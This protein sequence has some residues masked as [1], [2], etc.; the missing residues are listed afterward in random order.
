VPAAAVRP[1]APRDC[2]VQVAYARDVI[3]DLDREQ[4]L[5]EAIVRPLAARVP[6]PGQRVVD[7]PG[8]FQ[9]L[10]P[11][12][13]DGGFNEVSHVQLADD[14]ADAVIDATLAEYAAEGVRFKWVVSPSCRP[15][16]LAQRLARRG[17]LAHRC[18]VMAADIADVCLDPSPDVAVERVEDRAV[19]AYADVVA[20]GWGTPARPLADYQRLVLADPGD[21]HHSYLARVDGVPAGAANHVLFDRSAYL[22]GGVVLPAWRG[23]GAYRSLIAARLAQISG[24]GVR[25]VTTLAMAETSAPILTRLGFTPIAELDV[26]L[27]R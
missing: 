3:A 18:V 22:M 14:E 4:I 27:N 24:A 25:L 16:D 15:R 13:R 1:T 9:L 7:R 5:H 6:I 17:M 10:T 26:F 19:D 20:A 21:R 2:W 12:F 23:R 8:F 11:A